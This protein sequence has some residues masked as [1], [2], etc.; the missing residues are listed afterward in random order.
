MTFDIHSIPISHVRS[1]IAFRLIIPWLLFI[2]GSI[3]IFIAKKQSPVISINTNDKKYQ[4]ALKEFKENNTLNDL[5][6]FLAE[7]VES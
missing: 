7:Q 5:I 4:I 6:G 1:H 2:G 3:W